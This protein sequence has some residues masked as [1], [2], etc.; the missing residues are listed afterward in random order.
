MGA[1]TGAVCTP[2]GSPVGGWVL[3]ASRAAVAFDAMVER[4]GQV[5]RARVVPSG[6][7]ELLAPGQPCFLLLTD[8]SRVVGLWAIGEVVA[9]PLEL[10]TDRSGLGLA[11]GRYAEVEM[12]ALA[13]PLPL[14]RL[15]AH[16]A[17]GQSALA[18]PLPAPTPTPPSPA[19][20]RS[21]SSSWRRTPTRRSVSTAC[22]PLRTP[23]R[24]PHPEPDRRLGLLR[25]A[26]LRFRRLPFGVSLRG[27]W[28]SP[29]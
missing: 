27:W 13:K 18:A 15:V 16:K 28:R 25:S 9:P 10:T 11:P 17:L 8:R 26:D 20:G 19:A 4:F 22:S 7:V 12:L 29:R 21:T 6:L 24:T 5:F 1:M 14:D 2:E 23:A 3:R